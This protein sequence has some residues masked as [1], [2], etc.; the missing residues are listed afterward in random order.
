MNGWR[1]I[2]SST[3]SSTAPSSGQSPIDGRVEVNGQAA[4]DD[5]R[6]SPAKTT[7]AHFTAMQIRAGRVRG[8]ELHLRR[9]EAATLELFNVELDRDRVRAYM[10]H[11]LREDAVDA[12]VRVYVFDA[13]PEPSIMVTVR[14]PGQA[15][16]IAQRLRSVY[17]RRP[18]PH[19]K[20]LGGFVLNG[21]DAQTY[22]RQLVQR[23]GFDEALFTGPGGIVSEAAIANLGLIDGNAVV[24]PDA[25]ALHGITMQLLERALAER[26]VPWRRIPVRLADVPSFD[27]A[28]LSNARGI[29]AVSEIDGQQFEVPF[30]RTN[31]LINAYE[32][33]PWDEL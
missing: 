8:L 28:F 18:L 21:L 26:G 9:L 6:W 33:L 22:F 19:L 12:S 15:P 10:R 25:P 31:A 30:E 23:Q 5:E 2:S 27:G 7:Y 16:A 3:S 13:D 32:Q 17:Y 4:Q 20:H 24:W 1:A 14:P 11:A 29:V